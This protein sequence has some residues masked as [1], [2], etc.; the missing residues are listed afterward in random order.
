MV[1]QVPSGELTSVEQSLIQHVCLGERLD[2]TAQD[3][4]VD[5]AAMRSWGVSAILQFPTSDGLTI[6][7]FPTPIT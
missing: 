3:E 7:D 5:E 1:T 2:L 4:N 6:T